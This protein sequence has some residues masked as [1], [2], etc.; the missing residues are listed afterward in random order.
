MNIGRFLRLR[1]QGFEL[2]LLSLGD[3]SERVISAIHQVF[4]PAFAA[5]STELGNLQSQLVPSLL[6]RIERLLK[7][8]SVT[9]LGPAALPCPALPLPFIR[10]HFLHHT[11]FILHPTPFSTLCCRHRSSESIFCTALP[12]SFICLHF[13]YL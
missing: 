5:W 12:S 1:F 4:I 2:M 13:H 3:P 6:S 11:V 7:V 10:L 9:G 8:G